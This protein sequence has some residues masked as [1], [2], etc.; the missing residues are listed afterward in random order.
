MTA[1]RSGPLLAGGI[2]LVVLG[3]LTLLLLL[4]AMVGMV[5]SGGGPG[6]A[7][8]ALL[9]LMLAGVQ[10]W[11]GILAISQRALGKILGI[12]M[13]SLGVAFS[14]VGLIASLSARD[15]LAFD[16][17]TFEL[18]RTG[19]IEPAAVAGSIISAL[20]YGTVVLL[21]ALG[22]PH[23]G[24]ESTLAR[25]LGLHDM[26]ERRL[27]ELADEYAIAGRHNM[28]RDELAD[29]VAEAELDEFERKNR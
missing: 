8:W 11:S 5:Q 28:E 15:E 1:R 20:L 16:P 22:R 21:L 9:L 24:T 3:G 17:A 26:S 7:L 27:R 2:L 25:D 29:A 10:L 4:L 13:G 6:V 18:S 19:G 23:D 12:V 14:L